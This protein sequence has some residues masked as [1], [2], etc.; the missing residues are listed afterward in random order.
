MIHGRLAEIVACMKLSLRYFITTV[1]TLLLSW[2]LA[3]AGSQDVVSLPP[4][5]TPPAAEPLVEHSVSTSR[6]LLKL[7]DEK[8]FTLQQARETGLVPHTYVDRLPRDMASLPVDE[9]KS[10]FIR[11]LLPGI[12]RVNA[13][14][15]RLRGVVIELDKRQ[16]QGEQLTQTESEWLARLAR[17]YTVEPH[18]VNR[19]L[20]RMDIIPPSLAI[21][22]AII[23]SGWGRSRFAVGGN[24]LFGLHLP[25]NSKRPFLKASGANVKLAAFNTILESIE[26]YVHNL[27]TTRSYHQLRKVRYLMRQQNLQPN[28]ISLSTGLSRYSE[29]GHK[30]S[31]T[32]RSIITQNKLDALDN[33]RLAPVNQ[34][35]LVKVA[36]L[37][38]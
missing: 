28:G 16:K 10:L 37:T 17:R 27:N 23:E 6:L 38:P 13:H 5:T 15:E 4:L 21:T 24:V 26:A 36:Y 11:L 2:E 34:G 31:A 3:C 33:V 8:A 35:L 18:E 14:I 7:F 29:K 22:Q 19:L 20:Q 12:L 32:L 1:V 9:M 30:Y 25:T